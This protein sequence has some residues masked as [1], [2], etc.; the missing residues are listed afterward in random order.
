VATVEY[1]RISALC[2]IH[3]VEGER[4]IPCRAGRIKRADG[5]V[6]TGTDHCRQCAS[7]EELTGV[8]TNLT[9]VELD[10]ARV[11]RCQGG[12]RPPQLVAKEGDGDWDSTSIARR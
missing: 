6:G 3:Y 8:T 9:K 11:V 4:A 12:R 7:V 5:M 2:V 1:A 10:P